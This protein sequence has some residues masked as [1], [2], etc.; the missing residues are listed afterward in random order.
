MRHDSGEFFLGSAFFCVPVSI[1]IAFH[2]N[3]FHTE[4]SEK[5]R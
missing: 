3:V 4:E 5:G 2:L 1:E